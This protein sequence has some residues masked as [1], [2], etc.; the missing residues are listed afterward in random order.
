MSIG[1]ISLRVISNVVHE[2]VLRDQ[3]VLLQFLC[4]LWILLPY[5]SPCIIVLSLS[6]WNISWFLTKIDAFT[7]VYLL[8]I[9]NVLLLFLRGFL[10]PEYITGSENHVAHTVD[11]MWNTE[12]FTFARPL[13][14]EVECPASLL[15]LIFKL[16]S[17]VHVFERFLLINKIVY[18]LFVQCVWL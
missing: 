9:L 15:Q 18:T 5:R 8:T 1:V 13:L 7:V 12:V 17:F 16:I 11:G 10:N 4:I 2:T 3:K 6:S 14:H